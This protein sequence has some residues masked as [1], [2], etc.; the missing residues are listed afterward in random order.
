VRS[1]AA[2]VIAIAAACG[3]FDDTR[4]PLSEITVTGS[5]VAG[6]LVAPSADTFCLVGFADGATE[7][8]ERLACFTAGGTPRWSMSVALEHPVLVAMSDG[9]LLLGGRRGD[10]WVV[11]RRDGATG[12]VRWT[13]TYETTLDP[14]PARIRQIVQDG[15]RVVLAV[16]TG[17]SI[18]DSLDA[19]SVSTSAAVIELA[20][21]D[22]TRRWRAPWSASLLPR[23]ALDGDLTVVVDNERITQLDASG[24]VVAE[25]AR[26]APAFVDRPWDFAMVGDRD[27]ADI[28]IGEDGRIFG[29]PPDLAYTRAIFR[30]A[31][32]VV[33]REAR[34]LEGTA[35][36]ITALDL[37]PAADGVVM[38][39][40]RL[41]CIDVGVELHHDRTH[42]G[43][44]PH[45]HPT[46]WYAMPFLVRV[47]LDGT[48][49]WATDL[50]PDGDT[51]YLNDVAVA[52]D[53]K[54]LVLHRINTRD[55]G[56]RVT[57]FAP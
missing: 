9:D 15:E 34:V 22:G 47:A 57:T 46:T 44:L 31:D 5:L 41:G 12:G 27:V 23:V 24:A 33:T 4:A 48:T 6:E 55:G 28:A 40:L 29:V 1:A 30:D 18:Q 51:H 54:V 20:A 14:D 50:P 3:D 49:R 39:G 37:T 2:T 10:L 53:G 43:A 35:A 11:E 32:M 7:T 45:E 36:T 19:E 21:A 38:W 16:V 17:S 56:V 8:S 25:R 26:A 42:G 52:P 13:Y